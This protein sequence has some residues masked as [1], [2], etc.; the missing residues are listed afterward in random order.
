MF[1]V[2]IFF[3]LLFPNHVLADKPELY[4]VLPVNIPEIGFETEVFLGDS[5]LVQRRGMW[6]KCITPKEGFTKKRFTESALV[7]ANEEL[8]SKENNDSFFSEYANYELGGLPRIAPVTWTKTKK[9]WQLCVQNKWWCIKDLKEDFVV[10]SRKFVPVYK[11]L[12][13]TIEYN[14]KSNEVYNF[15]YSEFID[16]YARDAFTREFSFDPKEGN[17]IGYKGAIVEVIE[18]TNMKIKYKVIRN[19]GE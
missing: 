7:K 5:M 3:I 9:G 10:E 12:Q 1:F 2:I 11:S 19:F 8:C 15:I 18:A 17:L 4:V 6:V 13:Q 14:G 16:G